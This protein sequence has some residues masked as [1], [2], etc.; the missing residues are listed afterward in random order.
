MYCYNCGK[1]IKDG[2]KFCPYCGTS[3]QIAKPAGKPEQR[4]PKKIPKDKK[5]IKKSK[6]RVAIIILLVLAVLAAAAYFLVWPKINEYKLSQEAEQEA[7]SSNIAYLGQGFTDV[8]ITDEA[9]AI[10]AAKDAASALGYENALSETTSFRTA[11]VDGQS[12]YRLQQNYKGIPVYGRYVI[13]IA[14]EN[15]A[16]L[17]ISTD[18]KDIPE[19][20]SLTPTVTQA[21]VEASVKS[22]L[23]DNDGDSEEVTVPEL[24]N[25]LLVIYDMDA[26]ASPCLAYAFNCGTEEFVVNAY[27]GDVLAAQ[28]M[29]NC[30]EGTAYKGNFAFPIKQAN[31]GK[32]VIGDES[33]NIELRSSNHGTIIEGNT[34]HEDQGTEISSDDMIFGNTSGER[35]NDAEK[36]AKILRTFENIVDCYLDRFS[37]S[38]FPFPRVIIWYNDTFDNVAA[39]Y[40]RE[41]KSGMVV[42]GEDYNGKEEK[43]LAHEYTHILQHY[44]NAG[45]DTDSTGGI[46]EGLADAFSYLYTSDWNATLGRGK[47]SA[48]SPADTGYPA[49]ISDIYTAN[50]TPEHAYA[51]VI[52]HAAFL[53]HNSGK[54]NDTELHKLWFKTL[55]RL[56][57]K[58]SYYDLRTCMEQTAIINCNNEQYNAVC[59]AFDA[60][61]ICSDEVVY[62]NEI[63][64]HFSLPAGSSH[65]FTINISG[66]R[67]RLFG[68][69]SQDYSTKIITN[70]IQ[71][72]TEIELGDG[73]Y[74]IEVV[75]NND[76]L[77]FEPVSITV[78]SNGKQKNLYLV[79]NEVYSNSKAAAEQ[80]SSPESSN[81]VRTGLYIGPDVKNGGEDFLVVE[82]TVPF[83]AWWQNVESTVAIDSLN[84]NVASFSYNEGGTITGSIEFNGSTASMTVNASESSTSEYTWLRESYL[85]TDAQLKQM[86]ADLNVPDSLDIQFEQGT[87]YYWDAGECWLL[88]VDVKAGGETIAY[89]DFNFLTG[90]IVKE[91]YTYS[92]PQGTSTSAAAS[93]SAGSSAEYGSVL[94]TLTADLQNRQLEQIQYIS[95]VLY[96]Y[97][98]PMTQTDAALGGMDY[99]YNEYIMS[100]CEDLLDAFEQNVGYNCNVSYKVLTTGKEL[101]DSQ[102]EGLDINFDLDGLLTE[103]KDWLR[104]LNMY[105]VDLQ[106]VD[107]VFALFTAEQNGKSYQTGIAIALQKENDNWKLF[108]LY[109]MEEAMTSSLEQLANLQL[110]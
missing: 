21:Q 92:P 16:S 98:G 57:K 60:V 20:V 72:P 95:S 79:A 25:D 14:D 30:L 65:N 71:F 55:L 105:D 73:T 17:G 103:Q 97:S 110:S 70:I 6:L 106:D 23:S 4:K 49:K 99:L 46:C 109:P 104:D 75:E 76:K 1:K 54:F 102:I 31:D 85:F 42:C 94:D 22:Y 100:P 39:S 24:T 108:M 48:S 33:R 43:T 32:Y 78:K 52:S 82:Q 27:T 40:S 101:N 26:S 61:G 8:S 84:E 59:D 68:L 19:S 18:A 35:A 15:G 29:F 38:G 77:T 58:G 66:K 64:A 3:Q 44:Y 51:T 10:A 13:V 74:T 63:E 81:G 11:S 56:P 67:N 50:E 5:I 28:S 107:M 53:M 34:L 45:F 96:T 37:T 2:A 47:R 62:G 93:N 69:W 12:Y 83:S 87:P 7:L 80:N 36:G 86:A 9:S 91:I 90:E 41:I 89:A 88:H